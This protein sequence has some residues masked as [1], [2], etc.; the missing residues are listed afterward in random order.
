MPSLCKTTH[1]KQPSSKI[2]QHQQKLSCYWNT[3]HYEDWLSKYD[4]WG[5][6]HGQN[7]HTYHFCDKL[8]KVQCCLQKG[9]VT[10]YYWP[11]YPSCNNALLSP[12]LP[13]SFSRSPAFWSS[14]CVLSSFHAHFQICKQDPSQWHLLTCISEPHCIPHY[15]VPI[16]KIRKAI[17][18]WQ[19]PP[20]GSQ[21][22]SGLA[23]FG[24]AY[25]FPSCSPT[26]S[27]QNQT[28]EPICLISPSQGGKKQCLKEGTSQRL[29]FCIS[30][31]QSM[32]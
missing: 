22:I 6:E 3:M 27:W 29:F 5:Y 16:P 28:T 7:H 25:C 2:Q 32:A 20:I 13:S 26:Q 24:D 18:S 30:T 17:F 23:V 31:V 19:K 11:E 4:Q 10:N 12:V 21:Q 14:M 9:Q 8:Q 1:K 15:V